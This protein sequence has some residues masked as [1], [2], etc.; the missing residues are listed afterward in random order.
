MLATLLDYIFCRLIDENCSYREEVQNWWHEIGRQYVKENEEHLKDKDE[1]LPIK[2]E[3]YP[4]EGN[5]S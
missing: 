2:L 1:L 5:Y 4:F 3:N